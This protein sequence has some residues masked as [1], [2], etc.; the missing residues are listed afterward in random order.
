MPG[1]NTLAQ[2]TRQGSETYDQAVHFVHLYVIEPHPTSPDV[3]PYRGDV[4]ETEYSTL[5]Q[6]VDLAERNLNAAATEVLLKGKQLLLVDDLTP[7]GPVNPVW[8]TYGPA[9]NAAFLIGQNG[10]V[11]VQQDWLDVDAMRTAIDTLLE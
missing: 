5:G 3:S 9:P 8:C 7:S 6:P 2:T 1:L 4:W 11:E 10:I